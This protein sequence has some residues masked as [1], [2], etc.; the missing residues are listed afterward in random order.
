[1]NG[2]RVALTATAVAALAAVP[3]SQTQAEQRARPKTAKYVIVLQGDGMG[4]AQRDLIRLVT[5]G[6][7]PGK[8]LHMNRLEHAGLVHTDPA[9]PKQAVTDSAAAATAFA[10]G[11]KTFN[12]AIGVDAQGKPVRTLLEDARRM[13]KATGLVTTSQVTDATPAAYA[14]HVSDRAQQSEIARQ[15]LEQ[16][17]PDVILGGGEDYWYPAGTEGGWPDHPATDPSEASKGDKGNLVEKAKGLGYTYVSTRDAL[18][19]ARGPKLL[20]LFANEELFEHREEGK[21]DLY[22]PAVPLPEMASKALSVLSR[23]RDGFFVLIEEEGIDEMAHENN[24][25][26]MIKAGAA[27]DATVKVAVDFARSHPGTL[28]VVQGDH[29]TGGL[30]IENP[31]TADESGEELSKEDGPFTVKGTQLQVFADWTTGQHTGADTPITAS[32]PGSEAFDGVIDNTDV[33]DAIKRVMR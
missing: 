32:G 18:R 8:E 25:G 15:F 19:K 4:T 24:A 14:A 28:I 21:G 12:G 31:D 11:V 27:L 7:R 6:N 3:V 20:G 1:M 5:V 16:S 30:T 33:H 10:T 9:D 17:K 13:G 26:L 22:D 29:E 2:K 23:D